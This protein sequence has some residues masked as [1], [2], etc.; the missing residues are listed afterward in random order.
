[1]RALQVAVEAYPLELLRATLERLL[2]PGAPKM[3]LELDQ[4]RV[5]HGLDTAVEHERVLALEQDA[6]V[7]PFD[8]LR[9][10]GTGPGVGRQSRCVE[11]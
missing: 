4:S 11:R 2:G 5:F 7:L 6:V 3:I 1:M 8:A 9:R 10:A